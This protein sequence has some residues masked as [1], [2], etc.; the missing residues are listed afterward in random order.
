M[1][2]PKSQI[3]E[4]KVAQGNGYIQI[5]NEV[6]END[7]SIDVIVQ[8]AFIRSRFHEDLKLIN[9]TP[10]YSDQKKIA[11]RKIFELF[12]KYSFPYDRV[13]DNNMNV[14][15]IIPEEL[16][17]DFDSKQRDIA[18]FYSL[19]LISLKNDDLNRSFIQ[20]ECQI[21]R[22]RLSKLTSI[23][24]SD[25][26]K[27]LFEHTDIDFESYL[28]GSEF[29]IPFYYIFP[30]IDKTR[31]V[32]K[33]GI[34][35]LNFSEMISIFV[36]FYKS[37]LSK[38]C[39]N[40]KQQK[41]HESELFSVISSMYDE[42]IGAFLPTERTNWNVVSLDDIHNLAHRSFPPCMYNMFTKL[43][44]RHKLFHT[45]RLQLGLF[46]KGIGLSL[47]DSLKLWRD[48]FS[49]FGVPLDQFERQYAYNIRYNYGKEGSCRNFSPY[50]CMGMIRMPAPA[51]GQTHGCPF[52]QMKKDE[53]RDV[54]KD[55]FRDAKKN[56]G[57]FAE[58]CEALAE[59]GQKHPQIA[60]TELFNELH[61]KPYE[62]SAVRHPCEYFSFSEEQ[63]KESGK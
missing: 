40:L 22:L 59:K 58:K 63:F 47:K 34:V 18:S 44:L 32:L 15:N 52:I 49:K 30:Y 42:K 39:A 31:C 61:D 55:M 29:N 50:S 25:L 57:A 36:S 19:L 21:F 54:L 46:L 20:G 1:L 24:I 10:E 48:E 11:D 51:I 2:A 37:Y 7:Y 16:L 12:M 14:N 28:N 60:C 3:K 17:R 62:D 27:E 23:T 13:S 41:F 9:E 33:N 8:L 53:C 4:K 45:G 38:M 5:Y 6:P 43:Q 35:T 26:P 56:K